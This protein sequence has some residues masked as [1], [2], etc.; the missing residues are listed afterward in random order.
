MAIQER[1]NPIVIAANTTVTITGNSVGHFVCTT[2]GTLTI[3]ST[4]Y[5]TLVNA[6]T[7]TAGNI[8]P[9]LFA[10]G[11]DGGTATTAGGAVGCLG[12]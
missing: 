3:T 12:V 8:Y 10:L 2:S 7:V 5:G 11:S 4:Q 1:Y 9:L 6:L